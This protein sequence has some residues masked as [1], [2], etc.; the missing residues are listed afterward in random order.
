MSGEAVLIID[1][2]EVNLQL[3]RYSLEEAGFVV[4]TAGDAGEA[5]TLLS[6]FHPALILMDIQL[7]GMDG[8]ELTRLL[9]ADSLFADV[10]IVALTSYAMRGDEQKALVSGCD[11]YITKPIETRTFAATVAGILVSASQ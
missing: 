6:T 9:K 4:K 5:Q 8:L 11:G 1:D 7:P 3:A 10:K 2:N